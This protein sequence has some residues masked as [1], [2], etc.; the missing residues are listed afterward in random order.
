MKF[1]FIV[2][3]IFIRPESLK[4]NPLLGGVKI[5]RN[6]AQGASANPATGG[7][8]KHSQFQ[9]SGNIIG[10]SSKTVQYPG[11]PAWG[12]SGVSPSLPISLPSFVYKLRKNVGISGVALPPLPV[13]VPL[14]SI[15]GIP[16]Y[17]LGQLTE[18]DVEIS[19]ELGGLLQFNGGIAFNKYFALGVGLLVFNGKGD[20][21]IFPAGRDD[22]S[23]DVSGTATIVNSKLGLRLNPFRGLSIG[24]TTGL[25]GMQKVT[26]DPGIADIGEIETGGDLSFSLPWNS[27]SIG[28]SYRIGK[29]TLYVESDYS[30]ITGEETGISLSPPAVKPSDV[31]PTFNLKIGADYYYRRDLAFLAGGSYQPAKLGDGSQGEDGTHGYGGL[32]Y[33]LG[34]QLPIGLADGLAPYFQMGGGIEYSFMPEYRKKSI[35]RGKK[36]E[37]D[38]EENTKAVKRSHHFTTMQ[39]SWLD[40]L[41]KKQVEVLMSLATRLDHMKILI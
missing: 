12:D 8:L 26:V 19:G 9:M 22:V 29:S 36:V 23:I 37:D 13:S 18:S 17:I 21:S 41:I 7:L 16:L 6:T 3:L 4:A 10:Y 40:F 38:L 28:F 11:L 24:F 27:F 25:V 33:L 30:G 5:T 31:Y 34:T 2:L 20:V 35:R 14:P 32:E 15:E 1:V 39:L